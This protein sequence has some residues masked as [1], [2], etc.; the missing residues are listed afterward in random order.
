MKKIKALAVFNALALI[1]QLVVTYVIQTK[2]VFPQDVSEVSAK[3]ESLLTPAGFTFAIWGLI[4]TL[5]IILCLYHIVIAYKHEKYH[6]ANKE[7]EKMGSLFIIVNLASAAWLIAWVK[8]E[9]LVSVILIAVQLIGLIAIHHRL[10]MYNTLKAAGL[11]V[12]NQ[13]P[14]SIYLGWIGIATIANVSSFLVAQQW[15]GFG[16][17]ALQWAIILIS[18]AVFIAAFMILIRR[19]IY[20]GLVIA[21]GL[22]GIIVKRAAI[23]EALYSPIIVSAWAGIGIIG[24]LAIIQLVR[25]ISYKKPREIFPAAPI[26]LK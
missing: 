15:S 7:L 18:T 11:K 3:Y 5:L 23:N 13:F 25:N 19:N 21:W 4:Y 9:L 22:Y 17:P 26:P 10:G 14:L 24:L 2:A 1:I 6:P 16:L 8:E 20:F 12:C